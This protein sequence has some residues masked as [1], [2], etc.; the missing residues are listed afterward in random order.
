MGTLSNWSLVCPNIKRMVLVFW[1]LNFFLALQD[2]LIC[3]FHHSSLELAM[4]YK[5]E[6]EI[7]FSKEFWL[8]IIGKCCLEHRIQ[9]LCIFII[10]GAHCFW[11]LSVPELRKVCILDIVNS[12]PIQLVLPRF[13][14]FKAFLIEVI[15]VISSSYRVIIRMRML[16]VLLFLFC[17][18][19]WLAGS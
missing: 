15:A 7:N 13:F 19:I 14:F 6:S 5:K 1:A 10:P 11:I 2:I 18:A 8:L 12:S 9:A 16:V 4:F 17:H 3:L